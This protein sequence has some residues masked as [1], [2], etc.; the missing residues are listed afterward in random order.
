MTYLEDVLRDLT[1]EADEVDRLVAGLEPEQWARPT[2]APGW[3]VA[4]QVAH[5]DFIFR[6]AGAAAADPAAFEAI[7][8]RAK[9]GFDAAVNA[10]LG[11]Y[12][13]LSPDDL[14]SR[15]RAQRAS[16]IAALG[17]VPEDATVPW[18]VNP[19]PPAVLACAGFMEV[20]AH[21]QD[22]A[23]A[24]GARFERTDRIRHLCL[25]AVLTRDFGYQARG[26]TPPDVQFRYE[27]TAPSGEVWEFGPADAEQ[28]VVGSAADFCLLVTR[29]RHRDDLDVS[30]VGADADQWLDIAQAY[31]G[32][33][34]AGRTP[35]QFAVLQH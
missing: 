28:R 15:W 17:A 8:A 30:A 18:L 31:R 27:L 33:A 11:E 4:D 29:R 16:T 5:L 3:T 35:G 26:L 23:D 19:L 1:A 22:I 25:F 13:G 34:G 12:A 20:F 6:I 32:P 14:V 9:N 2:P 7:A 21:G 10:A 24:V